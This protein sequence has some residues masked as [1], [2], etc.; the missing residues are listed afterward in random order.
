AIAQKGVR[1]ITRGNH[2]GHGGKAGL[3]F[4]IE[5][6]DSLHFVTGQSGINSEEQDVVRVESRIHFAQIGER[7]YEQTCTGKHDHRKSNLRNNQ[8]TAEAN[9]APRCFSCA[10]RT[11][12]AI[13]KCRTHVDTAAMK[14]R[15]KPEK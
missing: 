1:R 8:A 13:L 5:S 9:A 12:G 6:L 14:R 7:A 10:R 2:T 4:T 3:Q 11:P 15:R